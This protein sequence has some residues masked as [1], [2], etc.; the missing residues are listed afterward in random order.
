MANVVASQKGSKENEK[1]EK[2]LVKEQKTKAK[3]EKKLERKKPGPRVMGIYGGSSKAAKSRR[4]GECEGC[5]RDDCGESTLETSTF[6][7]DKML[8]LL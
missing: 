6:Y 1:R 7:V 8:K 4:C 2:V 3:E 5:M